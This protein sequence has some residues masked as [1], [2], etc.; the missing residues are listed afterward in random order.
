[1]PF[2]ITT[3]TRAVAGSSTIYDDIKDTLFEV[4]MDKLLYQ[5]NG[6]LYFCGDTIGWV[7]SCTHSSITYYTSTAQETGHYSGAAL[8]KLLRFQSA[9]GI[10]LPMQSE[11]PYHPLKHMEP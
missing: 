1:M 2:H 8:Y 11:Y 7:T 10:H 3:S 5:S 6:M 9:S 4:V